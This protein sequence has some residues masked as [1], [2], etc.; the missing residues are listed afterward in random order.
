MA[1]TTLVDHNFGSSAQNAVS[2]SLSGYDYFVIRC[3]QLT[4]PSATYFQVGTSGPTWRTSGYEKAFVYGGGDNSEQSSNGAVVEAASDTEV[5]VLGHLRFAA[6]SGYYSTFAFDR[7]VGAAAS[8]FV[9]E[10]TE[11]VTAEAHTDARI[12]ADSG[13]ITVGRLLVIGVSH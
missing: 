10:T 6:L 4:I 13:N 2:W 9:R 5:N 3:Q 11:Y 1:Y 8:L 12:K 7:W